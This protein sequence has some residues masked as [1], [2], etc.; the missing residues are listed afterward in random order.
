M[1]FYALTANGPAMVQA[2]HS[3]SYTKLQTGF[4]CRA[5]TAALS[6]T[7]AQVYRDLTL[8]SC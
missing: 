6:M 7:R 4:L 5:K 8:R 1:R 2:H 3:F